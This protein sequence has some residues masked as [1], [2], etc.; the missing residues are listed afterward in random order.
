LFYFEKTDI[1]ILIFEKNIICFQLSLKQH[2]SD[3][4]MKGY[5]SFAEPDS[6]L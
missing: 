5:V 1:S 4:L 2:I 3:H 6:S